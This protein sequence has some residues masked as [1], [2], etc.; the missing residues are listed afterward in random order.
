[1]RSEFFNDFLKRVDILHHVGVTVMRE[2]SSIVAL[3]SGRVVGGR[4]YSRDE[5]RLFAVLVPHLQRAMEIHK[6][7]GAADLRAATTAQLLDTLSF[8]IVLFDASGSVISL[9]TAA[10][11]VLDRHDTR[12]VRATTGASSARSQRPARPEPAR[13]LRPEA[14]SPYV[15][16]P[17]H[18]PSR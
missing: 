2:E 10:K 5:V 12:F 8:G 13:G 6:R 17:G 16:H 11:R 9:N 4:S 18:A 14:R 15:A 1:M 3:L 7:L